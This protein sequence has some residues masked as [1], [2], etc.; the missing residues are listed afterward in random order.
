MG[1]DGS[2]GFG[3]TG[4][5]VFTGWIRTDI[6]WRIWPRPVLDLSGRT[7]RRVGTG[8]IGS[9]GR[10]SQ[11]GWDESS[12]PFFFSKI[13]KNSKILKISQN[14][15]KIKIYNNLYSLPKNYF[16]FLSFLF[17]VQK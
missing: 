17:K 15:R 10:A 4:Q 3:G 2:T 14:F 16:I 8:R 5:R 7:S 13:L 11:V 1:Y 9:K 6:F 12:G